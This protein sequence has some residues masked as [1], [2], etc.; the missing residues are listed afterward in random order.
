MDYAL[1]FQ[2]L[3][4]GLGQ[5]AIYASLALALVLIYRATGLINFAQGEMA[6]F[7]TYVTWMFWDRGWPVVAAIAASMVLSFVGGGAIER[8]IIRPV[9]E[10]R[11]HALPIVIVTIG[12]LL[13]L[14]ELAGWIWGSEGRT[15]PRVFGTG[16]FTVGDVAVTYQTVGVLCVLAVEVFLLF[17]LFQRTKLG[18]AMRAV[19]SNAESSRLVGIRFGRVLMF[20][21]GLAAAVGAL[22]GSLYASQLATLDRAIML[23]LLVYAFASATLGGFDSPLGAVVGGLVVGVVTVMAGGYVSWIGD[24]LKLAA[25]FVLIL[26]VLLVRPQGLFGRPQVERV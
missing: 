24:D 5:G 9:G 12:L 8:L 25:A 11:S 6:L 4:D 14:N 3:V 17:L 19:T 20:G 13:A 18:L 16:A 21:W 1:F 15:F 26:V 22:A 2:R 7:S 23:Q 10:V